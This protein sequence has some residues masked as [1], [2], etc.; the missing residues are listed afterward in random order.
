[1][2]ARSRHWAQA[3]GSPKAPR[4]PCVAEC[5]APRPGACAA[6]ARNQTR[7]RARGEIGPQP[8]AA[9][10][11]AQ[12]PGGG[13]LRARLPGPRPCLP[14]LCSPEQQPAFPSWSERGGV[15]P[16]CPG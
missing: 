15:A 6:R 3:P 4:R 1:M 8:R 10:A 16:L 12:G 14:S 2:A 11:G 5:A 9:Q 13:V 7:G